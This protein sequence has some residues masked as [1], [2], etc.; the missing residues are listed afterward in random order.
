M[1]ASA[2][3]VEVLTRLSFVW[4]YEKD[5]KWLSDLSA[6]GLH[7]TKPGLIRHRFEKDPSVRYEYRIDYQMLRDPK[8]MNAYVALFED[9]GW[10]LVASKSGWHYYRRPHVPGGAPAIYSD[11]SSLKELWRRV[12]F[13]LAALAFANVIIAAVNTLNL[14]AISYWPTFRNVILTVTGFQALVTIL[15]VYG[16]VRFQRK[17]DKLG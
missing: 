9:A 12:Q 10:T 6:Q 4:N 15:L 8:E 5:E 7:L 2:K 3:P 13:L 14:G 16:I 11:R 1:N 17:I